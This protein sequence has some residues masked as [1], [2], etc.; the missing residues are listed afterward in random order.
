MT[1]PTFEFLPNTICDCCEEAGDVV[2]VLTWD[3]C[4]IR[5]CSSCLQRAH[6]FLLKA[7]AERLPHG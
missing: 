7:V 4:G 1:E 6:A 3:P 2:D 5:L